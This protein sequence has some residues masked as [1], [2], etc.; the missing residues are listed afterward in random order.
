MGKRG[1]LVLAVETSCDETAVA[2]VQG[3]R[4]V[5]ASSVASQLDLHEKYGGVVP[6]LASRRHVEALLPVLNEALDDT[7]ASLETVDVIAAT[8]G[9]GLIGALLVGL[10]AG[11]ALS[12]ALNKP[13]VGVN[14]LVGHIY[15]NFLMRDFSPQWP[16]VCLIASGGHADL[17]FVRGHREVELLGRTRDDAAGEAFDKVAR[18]LG[19]GYPGGPPMSRLA[20]RGDPSAL[21]FPR[22]Y[23]EEGS[24][25][26]SFS[27]LKTHA[28]RLL[29]AREEGPADFSYEG[30]CAGFQEA[31][32]EVLANKA[33]AVAE[34]LG[35]KQLLLSGGVG[36]NW[37]LRELLKQGSEERGISFSVPPP[38]LCTDNAAMIGAAGYYLWR[39]GYASELSLDADPN[40]PLEIHNRPQS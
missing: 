21:D 12:F 16:L 26:F 33:L 8:Q 34:K 30:F 17:V 13:L 10:T 31:V 1:E 29:E 20:R 38:K 2:L 28:V 36:A 11:K 6:E 32:V 23:L 37:R 25:D 14:H 7:G 15:A 19:L 27:G 24:L 9:P 22:A 35:V 18:E 3:G 39:E 5:L 4:R 40:L